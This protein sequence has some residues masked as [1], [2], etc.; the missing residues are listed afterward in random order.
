MS[1]S[2]ASLAIVK[3]GEQ[4]TA[5]QWAGVFPLHL[6]PPLCAPEELMI[7]GP[8]PWNINKAK[9]PVRYAD[10]TPVHI[11]PPPEEARVPMQP[12]LGSHSPSLKIDKAMTLG[13][14]KN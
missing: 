9:Y 5:E 8:P 11:P 4:T 14:S 6:P 2:L 13:E 1:G 12:G 3:P 10:G 7:P